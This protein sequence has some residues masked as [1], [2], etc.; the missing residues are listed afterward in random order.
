MEFTIDFNLVRKILADEAW[1][2]KLDLG[3]RG[4]IA[5]YRLS[6][7]RH[8]QRLASADDANT[9]ACKPGCAWCCHFSVDVRPV[10]VFNIVE[11]VQQH[12]SPEQLQQLQEK[13]ERN[14]ELFSDMDEL[15]RMRQNTPCPFLIDS[16]CSIYAARPQTCRNYHATNVAGCKQSYEQPDN[17]DIAPDY[18][19]LVYQ[20]GAAHVD[21]FS[22]V[23][24]E[25]GY[26]IAAYE[27]N[28]ALA[29]VW[30]DPVATRQ[31]FE[32]RAPVF[33]D[34]EGTEVPQEFVDLDD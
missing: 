29:N 3:A 33:P 17:E 1:Q 16:R 12:F 5:A 31:R 15:Q 24:Q 19:P 6:L 11:H 21:A 2:T 9:L 8:D 14:A 30:A 4:P 7:Q 32:N 18:A 22:Q 34:L 28:S 10:E 13:V 27:L 20:S 23:M 25:A 26:D